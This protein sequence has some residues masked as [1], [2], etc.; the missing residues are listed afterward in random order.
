MLSSGDTP[1]PLSVAYD[2]QH[3]LIERATVSVNS[4]LTIS[5]YPTAK[6]TITG[7]FNDHTYTFQKLGKTSLLSVNF[8]APAATSTYT[9]TISAGS[10]L[11][12]FITV[13]PPKSTAPTADRVK[14]QSVWSVLKFW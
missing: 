14:K 4:P 12:L 9:F 1:V 11:S 13:T 8:I 7:T 10:P 3:F 5:L 2:S 6:G